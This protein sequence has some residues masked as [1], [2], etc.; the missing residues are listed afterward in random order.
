M[1]PEANMTENV[2]GDHDVRDL[3]LREWRARGIG[4][5]GSYTSGV[6]ALEVPGDREQ[7]VASDV[8]VRQDSDRLHRRPS[9]D[10]RFTKRRETEMLLVESR[11]LTDTRDG[12]MEDEEEKD[13]GVLETNNEASAT[14]E[15]IQALQAGAPHHAIDL[16]ADSDDDQQAS[17]I[18]S[19]AGYVRGTSHAEQPSVGV[20]RIGDAMVLQSAVGAYHQ[21]NHI[22]LNLAREQ[23]KAESELWALL[24]SRSATPADVVQLQAHV[25]QLELDH[26]NRAR[27]R[28]YAVARIVCSMK[29]TASRTEESDRAS[30]DK[31]SCVQGMIHAKC[32]RLGTDIS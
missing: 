2:E 27:E 6:D 7:L 10:E 9:V 29:F 16:I 3:E 1:Q 4:D 26:L 25:N 17:A 32:A 8:P 12:G 22:V 31:S 14:W 18:E 5:H 21:V 23:A 28:D 11:N 20:D 13:C 15:D 19:G 30:A 24:G